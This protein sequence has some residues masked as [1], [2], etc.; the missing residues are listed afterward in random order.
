M[1]RRG[2]ETGTGGDES[3]GKEGEE[4]IKLHVGPCKGTALQAGGQD[5]A[6]NGAQDGAG[7]S[8]GWREQRPKKPLHI[9][10]TVTTREKEFMWPLN[11]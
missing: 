3:F 11:L 1:Q 2:K 8:M 4:S 9:D 7:R 6:Q 10:P 5:G